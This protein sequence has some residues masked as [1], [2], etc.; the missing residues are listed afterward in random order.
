MKRHTV[1][2]ILT[3]MA[4]AVI[5]PGTP[6]R[7]HELVRTVIASPDPSPEPNP[8]VSGQNLLDALASIP[9]LPERWLLKIEP[10]VYELGCTSLVLRD[11]VDVEGS[12]RGVT[13]IRS[14]AE[15]CTEPVVLCEADVETEI[16]ELTILNQQSDGGSRDTVKS[17]SDGL[18]VS[19]VNIE[20]HEPAPG[21]T[22]FRSFK[23]SRLKDVGVSIHAGG[24]GLEVGNGSI[25][26]DVRIEITAVGGGVSGMAVPSG[27]IDRATVSISG[28][29]SVALG[30]I[31]SG[32]LRISNST[33]DVSADSSCGVV[34]WFG[35]A[36]REI[37]LS[38]SEVRA[39][40]TDGRGILVGYLD[41]TVEGSKIEG[42][43]SSIGSQA[44]TVRVG[45][46]RLVNPILNQ[47]GTFT[48]VSSY[49]ENFQEL[50]GTCE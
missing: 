41:L 29:A 25:L 23:R 14:S 49:D 46:S 37:R 24:L 20:I 35:G 31:T 39:T 16:R 5:F 11:L 4:V 26:R 1:F 13:T 42:T 6:A 48:C 2:L 8:L 38:H 44:G 9:P 50:S 45:A 15:G 34:D 7:A 17:N 10:G 36:G 12:G 18:V 3:F 33:I 22:G 47:G 28:S 27:D 40:G 21:G 30:I 43:T 19:R 32:N